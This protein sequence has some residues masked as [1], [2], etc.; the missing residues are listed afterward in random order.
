MVL[1][2]GAKNRELDRKNSYRVVYIEFLTFGMV[3]AFEYT[4]LVILL[5]FLIYSWSLI[6]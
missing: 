1:Y 3:D 2:D 6:R 4:Q 5:N